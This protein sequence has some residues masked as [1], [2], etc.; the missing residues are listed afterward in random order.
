MPFLNDVELHAR[1][2]LALPLLIVAEL[3]VHNRMRPV[4]RQFVDRRLVPDGARPAFDAAIASAMRLRNS[5][6]A[7]SASS[8][9]STSSGSG[10][11][12]DAVALRVAQLARRAGRRALAPDAGRLVAGLRQ[13]PAVPV[14]AAA[15]VLPVV[16]LGAVPVAGVAPRPGARAHA[17]GPLRRPGLSG[18]GRLRVCAGAGGAGGRPGRH[19]CESDLLRRRDSCRSSRSR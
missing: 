2:L 9:L 6:W 7:E 4:V 1:L 14:P 5:I 17:P 10:G 18:L 15:L 16:S 8:R 12:A 19:D 11:L 3:A 13:P